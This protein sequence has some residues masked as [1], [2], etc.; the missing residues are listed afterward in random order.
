[1]RPSPSS[2]A[3]S[4]VRSVRRGCVLFTL[5]LLLSCPPV[6][7][8]AD[9]EEADLSVGRATTNGQG[10]AGF[11]REKKS[12]VDVDAD[13]LDI[14]QANRVLTAK[15]NVRMVQT[16]LVELRADVAQYRMV[17]NQVEASGRIHMARQGDLFGAER[18]MFDMEQQTGT[19]QKVDVNLRGSGGVITAEKADFRSEGAGKDFFLL[20][21]TSFTNC[22]C[23]RP[24]WHITA[25]EAEIDR[26]NNRI[27]GEDILLYAGDVPVLALPWWRQP[28]LPK[29]ESGFLTPYFRTG[30]NGF[31]VEFPYYWNIAPNADATLALREISRRGVMTNAEYRYMEGKDFKGQLNFSG[32]YDTMNEAYRGLIVLDHEQP[33]DQWKLQAHVEES[34][35]RDFINDF[36]QKLVDPHSRRLDSAVE[37]NRFWAQ[38]QGYSSVQTG[39]H[40]FED[41]QQ[42]TD[43]HTVQ[44]LPFVVLD[45]SR[46]IKTLPWSEGK[47]DPGFGRWRLES[48]TRLDNF[49]QISGDITQRL[50]V[51]PELHFEKPVYVGNISAALGVR[52]T[53]YLLKGD[54]DQ[55]GLDRNDALHRESALLALRLDSTLRKLYGTS[56]LNTLEPSVQ[57]VLNTSSDQS[58]LP[59]YDASLRNFTTTDIF[60]HNLYSGV[61]RISAAQWVGYSLTSRLMNRTDNNSIWDGSVLTIGQRWAP[62]GDRAYQDGNAFSSVVSSLEVKLSENVSATASMGFNPYR[63]AL[64]SSDVVLTIALADKE[65]RRTEQGTQTDR[66]QI[67]HHFT[68]PNPLGGPVPAGPTVTGLAGLNG[69]TGLTGLP[70]S[71]TETSTER[72]QDLTV[73]ASLRLSDE[74]IWNQK[75]DYSLETGGLRS[76][77]TGLVYEHACWSLS[78]TGGRNL[79][80]TTGGQGGDF[81]G[82]FI[83][84]RGL[85]GVGI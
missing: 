53:A 44:N 14:D 12:P 21:N 38:D 67:G 81:I 27:T 9:T 79:T 78:L 25:Q 64:E 56:Y 60:A 84:L 7:S 63:D 36:E 66:I 55:T 39:V 83:N 34:R 16:G 50:D 40:W 47:W 75:F 3:R 77:G 80:S 22:V 58:K 65:H 31:E 45:D 4:P 26:A 76:W 68:D 62:E 54:P 32:I 71:L 69:L 72:A 29:R 37:V 73:D 74:W 61:D 35:S 28:L 10:R 57:Y 18:V 52:E 59:N 24:P 1:M 23:D 41:L 43:S 51:A 82:L 17:D 48:E 8:L 5:G 49:Y 11:A 30:S 20:K 85:G 46:P 2:S 70:A 19:F 42:P 15:G 6:F 13:D 33:L